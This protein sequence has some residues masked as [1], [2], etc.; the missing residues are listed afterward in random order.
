MAFEEAPLDFH[1]PAICHGDLNPCFP[2]TSESNLG[3]EA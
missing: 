2:D 3:A 1:L